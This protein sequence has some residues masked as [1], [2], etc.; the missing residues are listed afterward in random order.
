MAAEVKLQLEIL[1]VY[2]KSLGEKVDTIL[3]YQVLSEI[4]K[5]SV[6]VASK[7]EVTGLRGA[8]QGLYRIEIDPPSY[9]YVSQ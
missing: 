8:P 3:R 1:N 2:G 5:A 6:N 7:I 9:Q 4:R